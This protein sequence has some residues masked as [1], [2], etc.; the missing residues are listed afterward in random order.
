[1]VHRTFVKYEETATAI[2]CIVYLPVVL[3]E[4]MTKAILY[5]IIFQSYLN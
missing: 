4:E 1:M 5:Y 2:Q 3:H